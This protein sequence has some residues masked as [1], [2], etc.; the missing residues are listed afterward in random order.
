MKENFEKKLHRNLSDFYE[1]LVERYPY[2]EGRIRGIIAC[3][4]FILKKFNK[5]H[6]NN[7]DLDNI[8]AYMKSMRLT[9]DTIDY[10]VTSA[11]FYVRYIEDT[12]S[13]MIK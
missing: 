10:Y 1:F 7:D 8:K 6:I 2:P 12:K 9:K 3:T 13:V 4:G 5:L 11:G